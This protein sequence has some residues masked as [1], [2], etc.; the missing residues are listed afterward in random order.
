MHVWHVVA[1]SLGEDAEPGPFVDRKLRALLM[2]EPRYAAQRG[3]ARRVCL[4]CK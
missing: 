4:L 2:N 1:L 3:D